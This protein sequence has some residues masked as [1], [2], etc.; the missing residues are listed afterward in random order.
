MCFFPPHI[1]HSLCVHLSICLCLLTQIGIQ[2]HGRKEN[3]RRK[4][5]YLTLWGSRKQKNEMDIMSR[6][7]EQESKKEREGE[8]RE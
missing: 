3:G 5:K 8:K 2:E 1:F 6:K 7:G 4:K